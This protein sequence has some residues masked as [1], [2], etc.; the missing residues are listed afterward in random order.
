MREKK[1]GKKGGKVKV[2]IW[3]DGN[4]GYGWKTTAGKKEAKNGGFG[5]GDG[6]KKKRK[7]KWIMLEQRTVKG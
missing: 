4:F 6:K 2:R 7:W 3:G 5:H 1:D